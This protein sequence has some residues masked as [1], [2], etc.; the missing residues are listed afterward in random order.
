MQVGFDSDD[1]EVK[2]CET[3]GDFRFYGQA[4][5]G[6]WHGLTNHRHDTG[7]SNVTP[8]AERS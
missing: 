6:H 7:V 5:L 4:S 8:R 1:Y 3:R 2:L